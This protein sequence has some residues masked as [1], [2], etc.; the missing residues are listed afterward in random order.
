MREAL[1]IAPTDALTADELS[2]LRR[3]LDEAFGGDFSETDW[4]NSLG[5]LH[6]L[7]FGDGA[8]LAHAAIVDRIL[9]C[10]GKRLECAYVEAVAARPSAQGRGCGTRVMREVGGRIREAYPLGALSTG[11]HAFYEKLGWEMWRGPAWVDAAEGPLR[12]PDDDGGVMVLRTPAT[13]A[14]DL[15][16]DIICD[17][18]PGDVW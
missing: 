8:L 18:R 2:D 14:L 10:S 16:A 5:G 7:L 4:E 3:L 1:R 6:F 15:D 9:V 11:E 17:P 12:T 13:P